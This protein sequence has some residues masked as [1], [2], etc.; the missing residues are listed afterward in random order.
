ML[1]TYAVKFD[2]TRNLK[3]NLNFGCNKARPQCETERGALHG[4]VYIKKVLDFDTLAI[5]FL[6]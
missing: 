5:S 1:Y 3:K 2:V 4:L 6:I